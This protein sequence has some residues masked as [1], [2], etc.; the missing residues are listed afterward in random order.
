MAW[1]RRQAGLSPQ[2]DL[3]DIFERV[4]AKGVLIE[5]AETADIEAPSRSRMSV[6]RSR[7]SVTSGAVSKAEVNEAWRHCFHDE[8]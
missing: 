3:L 6:T 7:M 5:A 1:E 8:D 4:V 2:K